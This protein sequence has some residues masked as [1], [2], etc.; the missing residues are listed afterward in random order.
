MRLERVKSLDL[1]YVPNSEFDRPD[2]EQSILAPMPPAPSS[3]HT[4]RC[5]AGVPSYLA[6]LYDVPL[7]SGEQEVYLFRKLNYLKCQ[8]L[9]QRQQLL[10]GRGPRGL[11]ERV[12][13]RQEQILETKNHI[14][15]ANLRLVVS[16]AKR[17]V[18]QADFYDLISDGN[19]SLIRAVEKF[20]Y[21]YGNKFSTYAT[22]AIKKGFARRF[23]T[24][25]RHHDRFHTGQ[26]ERLAEQIEHRPDPHVQERDQRQ[27]E[28][29]VRRLFAC[30][31]ARERQI[32]TR[33]YG[34]AR[35][36]EPMTLREIGNELGVS[37]ERI[38][39]IESRAIRKLRR[40]AEY[41][42][43]AGPAA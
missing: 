26:D 32:V 35:G 5:P 23:V 8:A 1:D 17:Y 25:M 11:L 13:Q 30:L 7:L 12:E 43:V 36:Q 16:I 29:Q 39:Q 10:S 18:G 31:D 42:Q 37:K 22:W 4:A 21:S 33:R 27:R 19:T 38:R 15:R 41:H 2:A 24:Q 34:L 14:I 28:G 3:R 20:D 6:G 40:A 9:R